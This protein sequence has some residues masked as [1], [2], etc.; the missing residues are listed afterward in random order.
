M[1]AVTD[2]RI[3]MVMALVQ[4]NWLASTTRSIILVPGML[5]RYDVRISTLVGT[6]IPRSRSIELISCIFHCIDWFMRSFLNL[7]L[8][9]ETHRNVQVKDSIIKLTNFSI[10][11]ILHIYRVQHAWLYNTNSLSQNF[12]KGALQG[13]YI[14]I[15]QKKIA[16]RVQKM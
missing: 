9:H 2:A 16:T 15:H 1:T 10:T 4:I 3:M 5:F 13:F 7:K 8:K 14:F 12:T 11:F 6:R